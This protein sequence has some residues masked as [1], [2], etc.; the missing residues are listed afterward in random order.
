[1][2]GGCH[3]EGSLP[4]KKIAFDYACNDCSKKIRGERFTCRV[5]VDFDLCGDC[6]RR[7]AHAPDHELARSIR[8]EDVRRWHE[9]D[10]AFLRDELRAAEQNGERLVVLTH[11]APLKDSVVLDADVLRTRFAFLEG[12]DLAELV[13][14]APVAAWLFGHTHRAV[15]TRV[16]S[17]AVVA[18]NPLGYVEEADV[19]ARFVPH[20][21]L[22]VDAKRRA[23][24]EQK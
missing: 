3:T 7:G 18:S 14:S 2:C 11:H 16:P 1:M 22:R 12:T 17:G 23:D 8:L 5:C 13:A 21:L 4:R 20:S 15:A 9:Q 19:R 24:L 10:V 6:R